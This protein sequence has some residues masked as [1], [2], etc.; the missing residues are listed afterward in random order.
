MGQVERLEICFAA[1]MRVLVV[2][3]VAVALVSI[4]CAAALLYFDKSAEAIV[5]PGSAA[6]G[7]LATLVPSVM[8]G[9]MNTRING[10]LMVNR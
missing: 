7:G 8:G 3:L 1:T 5:A 6:I 4:I 9:R 2:G 10:G